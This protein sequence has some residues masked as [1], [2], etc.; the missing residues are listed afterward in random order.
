MIFSAAH[1]AL[2]QEHNQFLL[3]GSCFVHVPAIVCTYYAVDF[4][5]RTSEVFIIHHNGFQYGRRDAYSLS[6]HIPVC[7]RHHGVEEFEDKFYAEMTVNCLARLQQR[8]DTHALLWPCVCVKDSQKA[9]GKRKCQI[10][11]P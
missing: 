8:H 1:F 4:V 11:N 3:L 2:F 6:S 7:P 10:S 5:R 9:V